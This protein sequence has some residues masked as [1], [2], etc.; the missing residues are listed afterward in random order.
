M[1]RPPAAPRSTNQGG[2]VMS[3]K[4]DAYKVVTDRIIAALEEGV[5]PWHKPWKNVRG[6][7]PTSLSS[8]KAYRGINVWILAVEQMLKGYSTPYWATFKQ[9]KERAVSAARA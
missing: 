8:G 6:E 7:G 3:P 1:R 9:A 2:V 5:V 4:A